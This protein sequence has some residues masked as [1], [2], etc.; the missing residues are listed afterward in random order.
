MWLE[1]G[2]KEMFDFLYSLRLWAPIIGTLIM[3]VIVFIMLMQKKQR[4]L[5]LLLRVL[6]SKALGFVVKKEYVPE[7][8][9][10]KHSRMSKGNRRD[11]T[12]VPYTK[13]AQYLVLVMYGDESYPI[14]SKELYEKVTEGSTIPVFVNRVFDHRGQSFVYLTED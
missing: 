9:V 3:S 11:D 12:F 2:E 14:D 13:E 8:V 7:E 6:R 4:E 1:K 10:A 5:A